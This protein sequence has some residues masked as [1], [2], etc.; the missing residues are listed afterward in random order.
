MLRERL[1]GGCES[2]RRDM[3]DVMCA[4]LARRE[5]SRGFSSQRARF[6]VVCFTHDHHHVGTR[7]A[8]RCAFDIF[9]L[10]V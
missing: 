4:I 10:V 3:S 8:R 5:M 1:R 2:L 7:A 6:G 9:T